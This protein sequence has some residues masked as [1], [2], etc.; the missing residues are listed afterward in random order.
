MLEKYRA[1]IFSSITGAVIGYFVFHPYTMTMSYLMRVYEG[2]EI[3]WNWRNLFDIFLMNFK[4]SMLPMASAFAFFGCI[5]GL[6]TG[7]IVERKKSSYELAHENEK[8]KVALET[9][10]RLMVTLSHYLLNANVVIGGEVRRARKIVTDKGTLAS[11]EVLEKEAKKIDSVIRA[12]RQVTEI[13]TANYTSEGHGL[14][15]DITKEIE[16]QLKSNGS[17]SSGNNESS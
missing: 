15:I 3:Y 1:H 13:K 17:V 8:K 5:I 4:P 14:M 16:E 2:G 12:L 7:V 10:R 11:L 9:L 6:L